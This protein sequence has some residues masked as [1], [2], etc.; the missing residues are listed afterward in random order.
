MGA[1]MST[2]I[3]EAVKSAI[4]SVAID[5][6]SNDPWDAGA[7]C[8]R[9]A[10]TATLAVE[11]KVSTAEPVSV[12][13]DR[14]YIDTLEMEMVR[15]VD[16]EWVSYDDYVAALSHVQAPAP[17]AAPVQAKALDELHKLLCAI[18]N[19]DRGLSWQLRD[20]Y[21]GVERLEVHGAIAKAFKYI[22]D[23]AD[24]IRSAL[25]AAPVQEWQDISTAPNCGHFLLF[26]A[27]RHDKAIRFTGYLAVNGSWYTDA[28]ELCKPT[29]WMLLPASP[30]ALR[31][32]ISGDTSK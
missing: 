26:G 29:H 22:L 32:L 6:N 14:Y 7:M 31:S 4:A 18:P 24:A 9:D 1:D 27:T 20:A 12:T 5:E 25:V 28:G 2:K 15:R 16:G 19:N 21:S 23:N 8:V 30:P 11:Q 17:V 3:I 10:I 13:V